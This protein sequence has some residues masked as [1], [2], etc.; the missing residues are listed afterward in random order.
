MAEEAGLS[1]DLAGYEK[2]MEA[3]LEA[4]AVGRWM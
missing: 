2:A 3:R 4:K 1:V